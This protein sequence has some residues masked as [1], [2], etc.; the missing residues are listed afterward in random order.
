MKQMELEAMA[1]EK[2]S[3]REYEQVEAEKNRRK[4][5]LVAEIKASGFGAM[6]DVNKN[7]QSDFVDQMETMRKTTEYQE[8]MNMDREKEINKGNQFAQKMQM[9]KEKMNHQTDLKQMEMDIARENKNRFD[10]SSKKPAEK[11]KNKS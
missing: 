4:D 8:T 7:L 6:Q 2:A 5:L 9:E 3:E 1:Q 10:A 11:K